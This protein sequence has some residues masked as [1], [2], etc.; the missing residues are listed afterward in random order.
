MPNIFL[1]FPFL[2]KIKEEDN[3]TTI[4]YLSKIINKK[5]EHQFILA[6]KTFNYFSPHPREKCRKGS[7]QWWHTWMPPCTQEIVLFHEY[8]VFDTGDKLL[9]THHFTTLL[10]Y[11]LNPTSNTLLFKETIS[12]TGFSSPLLCARWSCQDPQ[13]WLQGIQNIQWI[14]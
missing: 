2:W 6:I 5:I 11:D 3:I 12:Q 13:F 10:I 9:K 7:I 14:I 8:M 1:C 4:L